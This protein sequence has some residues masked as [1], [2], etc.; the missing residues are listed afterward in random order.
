MKLWETD[1]DTAAAWTES[2]VNAA[3]IGYASV[4]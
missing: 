2:G 1:P 4:A 3:E